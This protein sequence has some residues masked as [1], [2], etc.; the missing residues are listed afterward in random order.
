MFAGKKKTWR[1]S[2]LIYRILLLLYG[3]VLLLLVIAIQYLVKTYAM[4]KK[5]ETGVF[6]TSGKRVRNE[7]WNQ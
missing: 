7:L 5:E 1:M 6:M 4:Q 2:K 3:V